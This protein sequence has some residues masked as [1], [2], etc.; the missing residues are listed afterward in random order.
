[1]INEETQRIAHDNALYKASTPPNPIV[2]KPPPASRVAPSFHVPEPFRGCKVVQRVGLEN[3]LLSESF[4]FEVR[5]SIGDPVAYM[6]M[7]PPER[8]PSTM[9]PDE[10]AGLAFCNSLRIPGVSAP[11]AYLYNEPPSLWV[12]KAPGETIGSIITKYDREMVS[13]QQ[14]YDALYAVGNFLRQLH[15]QHPL[16]F[17]AQA[18]DLLEVYI[19]HHEEVLRQADPLEAHDRSVQAAVEVFRTESLHLRKSG[20]TCA[21]LHG[22]AN[23]GNFLWDHETR[24]LSVIDLQRLGTQRRLQAPGFAAFEYRCFLNVLGFYPNIGFR[25]RRGGLHDACKAFEAGYGDVNQ[26]EDNF[27]TSIRYIRRALAGNERVH[28][29]KRPA[30]P[31]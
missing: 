1:M 12:H 4:I 30:V 22:D 9:L 13:A 11:E 25:G 16:P 6:K 3:G 20:L 7:L 15:V 28:Q 21:L 5:N 18:K 2:G 14:V 26:H 24:H 19:E 23:C 27:F 17:D 29:I 10:A 8:D 31:L